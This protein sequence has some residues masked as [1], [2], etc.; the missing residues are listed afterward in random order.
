MYSR[1]SVRI[2]ILILFDSDTT[3]IGVRVVRDGLDKGIFEKSE[4]AII[5][6]GEEKELHTMVFI[7]SQDTPTYEAKDIGLAFL[8]EERWPSDE[9]IIV[10]GNEQTGRFKTVL[11]ALSE[12]APHLAEKDGAHSHGLLK[13]ASGQDVLA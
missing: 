13:L 9:S 6:N 10:T 5:Y 2:L 4:G 3:E 11:A 8:K 1:F 12:M 7:T